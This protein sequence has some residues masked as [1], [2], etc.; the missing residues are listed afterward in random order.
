MNAQFEYL[1]KQVLLAIGLEL[2]PTPEG[3]YIM[4]VDGKL[5]IYLSC[6][7]EKW[8]LLYCELGEVNDE[9]KILAAT[10]LFGKEWP[11]HIIGQYEEKI[12]FW[13]QHC[14]DSL[15]PV[16]LKSWLERFIQD[17]EG[18]LS[19]LLAFDIGE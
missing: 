2:E 3:L 18:Q 5:D 8:V 19:E 15:T 7:E 13:S 17:A 1:V 12:I 4:E 10:N 14:L 6:H 11:A 16:E 9:S